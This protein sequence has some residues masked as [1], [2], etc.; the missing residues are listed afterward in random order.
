MNAT[1]AVATRQV[2]RPWLISFLAVLALLAAW[3]IFQRALPYFNVSL[4][5]YGPYFWPRRWALVLHVAGGVVALTVGLIQLWLGLTNRATNLHRTLGKV[6]LG[7]ILIG[8]VGGFYLAAT[9]PGNAP[10]AAGL[11]ALCVA[12]VITTSMAVLAIRRRNVNQHREWMCRS[13]AVTFA[14]VTFRFGVDAVSASGA[15][16]ADA[17]VIMAWACWAIP[18]LLLE[19]LLQFRAV[20]R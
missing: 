12:W 4:S 9:I 1:P 10:Y 18:L 5:Q 2:S 7:S 6:Y 13:Y 8:S 15:A 16:F 3:F 14:F 17:Q 20:A 11:F 19:P